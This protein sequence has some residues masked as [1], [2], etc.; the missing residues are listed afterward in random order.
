MITKEQLQRYIDLNAARIGEILPGGVKD[1]NGKWI[2]VCPAMDRFNL[3]F[4]K[5]ACNKKAEV[6]EQPAAEVVEEAPKKSTKKTT[7][8]SKKK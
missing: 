1:T 7:K 8:K 3:D 2:L 5:V 6:V 4:S